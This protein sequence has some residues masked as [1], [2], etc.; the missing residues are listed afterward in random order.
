MVAKIE[1]AIYA[2]VTAQ[3]ANLQTLSDTGT[4][5]NLILALTIL[6]NSLPNALVTTYTFKPLIGVSTITDSK[7]YTTYYNYDTFNRLQN[8]KDA[9]GNI[10]SE[11]DYHYKP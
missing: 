6:R 8:V 9:Q 11:N 4:E 1:N 2:D 5:A 3:V 10:L 7:G